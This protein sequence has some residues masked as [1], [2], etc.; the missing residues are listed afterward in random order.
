MSE[1]DNIDYYLDKLE[2]STMHLGRYLKHLYVIDY[3][4]DHTY[5]EVFDLIVMQNQCNRV[6]GDCIN[7]K[8]VIDNIVK[9]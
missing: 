2:Q 6:K 8:I 1:L 9:L 5:K 4:S 3:D 7:L